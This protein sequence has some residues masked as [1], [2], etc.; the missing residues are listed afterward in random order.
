MPQLVFGI[1]FSLVHIV[2][3]SPSREKLPAG[4]I[5]LSSDPLFSK[6]YFVVDKKERFLYLYETD[7]SSPKLVSQY[8]ADIGKNQGDKVKENDFRTPVGIYFLMKE[9]TNPEIPFDLYG[10]IAFTTDYPNIFDQRKAKTGSGIWLH[11]VP[12][13]VPLTRG[14]RG[15]V[16]VRDDV[17]K[18]LKKYIKL[19]E[20]PLLIYEEVAYLN[21]QEYSTTKEKMLSSVERWRKAWESQSIDDYIKFYDETFKNAEMNFR[22]WYSHKKKTKSQYSFIKV[23]IS[24]P[25]ILRNQDQVVI[26]F[27][28]NYE[29]DLH[30]DFGMKTI[31]AKW[32]NDSFKIIREDWTAINSK[33]MPQAFSAS[34]LSN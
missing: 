4:L 6:Y 9:L 20:T 16:V 26:R 13:T 24:E 12:D 34:G 25:V 1:F 30:T 21:A 7:N 23:K 29:S 18:E 33:I 31:H 27:T 19:Q 11:A 3:A 22:Q 10:S 8:P 17:V 15:C 5:H 32:S 2:L 14:S 28:Q